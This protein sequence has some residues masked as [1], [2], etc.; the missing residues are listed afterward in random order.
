[1]DRRRPIPGGG[2]GLLQHRPGTNW[3]MPRSCTSWSSNSTGSSPPTRP[4]TPSP[5][6]GRAATI[7]AAISSS[8]RHGTGPRPWCGTGST[9][10][11]KRCGGSWWPTRRCRSWR[12]SPAGLCR[13]RRSTDGTPT[14]CWTGSWRRPKPRRASRRALAAVRPLAPGL[15]EATEGEAE[16]IRQGVCTGSTEELAE[17]LGRRIDERFSRPAADSNRPAGNSSPNGQDRRTRRS[18]DFEPLIR[19]MREVLDYDPEAVW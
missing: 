3:A 1:M 14:P 2:P 17:A 7:D 5:S 9:T 12:P 18:R 4:S 13:R 15:C 16:A 6:G 11:S 19:R 10:P 8:T